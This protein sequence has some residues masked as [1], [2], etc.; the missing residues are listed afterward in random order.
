MIRSLFSHPLFKQFLHFAAV[1]L[2]GTGIQYVCLWIG[3]EY[4]STQANISSAMGY[5]LGTVANYR[6][7]YLFTFKSEKSHAEA[8]SK[9]Y[10]VVGIGWGINLGLMTLLAQQWAWNYWLAQILTTTIGLVWN[11]TG[12]RFWAFA[13]NTK[14]KTH[15][16]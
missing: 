8:V 7:N 5:L 11:F 1:G 6:L 15:H 2:T 3:V 4:L 14:P 16:E 13:D 12:S 10:A 9:Y